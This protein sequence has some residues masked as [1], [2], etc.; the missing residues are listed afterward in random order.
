MISFP[1]FENEA[2]PERVFPVLSLIFLGIF[3]VKLTFFE[4]KSKIF[5]IFFDF[6]FAIS[7]N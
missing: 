7:K 3:P 2:H 4:G 1:I 5:Q 6:P